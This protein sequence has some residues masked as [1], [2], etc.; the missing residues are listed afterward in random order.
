MHSN[1]GTQN[2]IFIL[3]LDNILASWCSVWDQPSMF[4]LVGWHGSLAWPLWQALVP[5]TWCSTP[6][7]PRRWG[8]SWQQSDWKAPAASRETCW[9]WQLKPIIATRNR[10]R[11]LGD[12]E[13]VQMDRWKDVHGRL[14]QA[15]QS[16]LHCL[17]SEAAAASKTTAG[18]SW[19]NLPWG[20]MLGVL[21]CPPWPFLSHRM[22]CGSSSFS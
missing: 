8:W 13:I 22:Q 6:C 2:S 17:G 15:Q 3:Y 9:W 5:G 21:H 10:L 4:G 19:V 20:S 1:F 14:H 16:C 12:H 7:T 11:T 18:H